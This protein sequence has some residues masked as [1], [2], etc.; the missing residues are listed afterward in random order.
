MRNLTVI[1]LITFCTIKIS[2]QQPQVKSISQNNQS[3]IKSFSDSLKLQAL[4]NIEEKK[5]SDIVVEKNFGYIQNLEK[6]LNTKSAPIKKESDYYLVKKS[7]K[8]IMHSKKIDD[9][10][11]DSILPQ[12]ELEFIYLKFEK[13]EEFR[14]FFGKILYKDN[15]KT[16]GLDSIQ[17][18]K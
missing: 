2:P 10:K 5:K 3:D 6:K 7:I 4:K 11:I 14:S 17:I 1:F 13:C 15:C 9:L 18:S 12:K 8:K 16:W